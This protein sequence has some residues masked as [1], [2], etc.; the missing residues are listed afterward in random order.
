MLFVLY[1]SDP[2]KYADENLPNDASSLATSCG[3]LRFKSEESQTT[4]TNLY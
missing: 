1:S 3:L 4:T 2:D